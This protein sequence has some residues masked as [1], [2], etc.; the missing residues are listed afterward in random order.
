MIE[1]FKKKMKRSKWG[2]AA[3]LVARNLKNRL[4]YTSGNLEDE[5]GATHQKLTNEESVHYIEEVFKDYL[6]YAKLNP[7]DLIDKEVLEIGYGDNLGV[8][9]KFLAS[10]VKRMVCLD[11]YHSVRDSFKEKNI[12]QI[13][14]ES[15]SEDETN[16]FDKVL[17]LKVE[18]FE[19]DPHFLKVEHGLSIENRKELKALGRFDF[20]LSRAVLEHI[21]DL[22][23][24]FDSMNDLL[25][26]GGLLIHK[27]DFR[28]HGL[29]T[30]CGHHPLTF[31]TFPEV[32]YRLM[33]KHSG[34]PN[35]KFLSYYRKKME[36]LGY[37]CEIVVTQTLG[38]S[39]KSLL[40]EIRRRLCT[41]FQE[42]S[43]DE[44]S[45]NGIFLIARKSNA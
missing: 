28:D 42:L 45:I 27:I 30:G 18:S 32:I 43:D 8:A 6:Q 31:L 17:R 39:A 23:L 12:Y 19:L 21:F 34:G 1:F 13:L 20:I 36:R 16:R 5:Y 25:K 26:A 41:Q 10:G 24:A 7:P 14:R 9:L 2:I 11:K 29:F 33:T 3:Y 22:D 40:N 38:E 4:K 35:R 44:L 15:L 37:H